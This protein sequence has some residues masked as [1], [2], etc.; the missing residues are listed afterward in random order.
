M[1]MASD[2]V[3]QKETGLSVVEG[4]VLDDESGDGLPAVNIFF[5]NTTA[6][7]ISD[8]EGKYKIKSRHHNDTLIFRMMGYDEVKVYVEPGKKYR[9]IIHLKEDS[10]LLDEVVIT[11]GENPAH[12]ILR[13]IIA[14][15][16]KNDP[17]RFHRFNAQTYTTLAAKLT[18]VTKENLKLII[19]APLIKN[20]PVVTEE[21]G[22]KVL[23]FFLSEKI[24]DNFIDK[25]N[26]ISQTIEKDKKVK[27]IMGFDKLDISGYDNSLSAEMN[28]YK[29]YVEL[30]GHTF[31]SPLANNGLT[32][33]RYYLEDSTI[34]DGKKHYTIKYVPRREKDLA[35][36]G[37]FTAIEGI[38]A[39]SKIDAT[40]TRK[41]NIN[42]LNTFQVAFDYDF[43]NDSTLFFKSNTLQASFHYLKIK[44]L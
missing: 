14:N 42:Y 41:A 22:R 3:A 7:T 39:I 5:K 23:P 43:V 44:K 12:P 8:F 17:E 38:W 15:K 32:F 13:A 29:N 4:Y 26:K 10:Q 40:L 27:S 11:P 30:F 9:L 19:P 34:V 31:I 25:D 20:L 16:D 28:F 2:V 35:F 18:N 6:G 1:V 21:D 36:I 33:Y 24:A 37:H